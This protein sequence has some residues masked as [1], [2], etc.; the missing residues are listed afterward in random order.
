MARMRKKRIAQ[1]DRAQLLQEAELAT[2][3]R[4][5]ME[6]RYLSSGDVTVLGLFD[7]DFPTWVI[8]IHG[9]DPPH[10]VCLTQN[11]SDIGVYTLVGET[12]V[13]WGAY[14]GADH[15]SPT[16]SG[17]WPETF[18]SY[19]QQA[20]NNHDRQNKKDHRQRP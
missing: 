7:L 20:V 12:A 4:Y 10:Y 14:M 13:Q 8:E 11:R 16:N 1:M 3:K 17:D 2:A 15:P 5:P 19:H 6:S 18:K 9:C